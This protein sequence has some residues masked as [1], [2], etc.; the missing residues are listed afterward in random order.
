MPGAAAGPGGALGLPSRACR[1]AAMEALARGRRGL[2]GAQEPEPGEPERVSAGGRAGDG[3]P[4]RARRAQGPLAA[5]GRGSWGSA[6]RGFEPRPRGRSERCRQW[7]RS[8]AA[9]SA[10]PLLPL[11]VVRRDVGLIFACR[12]SDLQRVSG[13]SCGTE[14]RAAALTVFGAQRSD[15]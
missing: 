6:L 7:Q 4:G 5:S 13:T 2:P 8:P 14:L 15:L 10:R 12:C 9:S 3:G 1:H 11:C